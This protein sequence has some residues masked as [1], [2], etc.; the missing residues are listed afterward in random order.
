MGD[1]MR[2]PPTSRTDVFSRLQ[3]LLP[4]VVTVE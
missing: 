4:P 3:A 2:V 1:G